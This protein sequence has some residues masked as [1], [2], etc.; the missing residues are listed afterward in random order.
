MPVGGIVIQSDLAGV[1]GYGS[2]DRQIELCCED[3]K[4][5]VTDLRLIS[6]RICPECGGGL[7]GIRYYRN[8]L[9]NKILYAERVD[10]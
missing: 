7:V 5:V 2:I 6:S 4:S 9:T 10:L 8:P 1:A 3:C